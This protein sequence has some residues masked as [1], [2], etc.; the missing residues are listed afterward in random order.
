MNHR[1]AIRANDRE[2]GQQSFRWGSPV[3][4]RIQVVDEGELPSQL[5]VNRKKIK[6]AAWHFAEQSPGVL[7]QGLLNLRGAKLLFALAVAYQGNSLLTLEGSDLV[8]HENGAETRRTDVQ[9]PKPFEFFGDGI[10]NLGSGGL[11]S[12]IER[13]QLP[14][15]EP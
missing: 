2:I 6:A 14:G 13:S 5:T 9:R 3:S 4:K 15:L 8:V 1:V 10:R 12:P 11:G 7:L